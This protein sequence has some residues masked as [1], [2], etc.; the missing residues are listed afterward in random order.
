MNQ[1]VLKAIVIALPLIVSLLLG[2][3]VLPALALLNPAA[4]YC[5]SLG[6]NYTVES[7]QEGERGLCQLPN[8]EAVD[9]WQFLQGKVAPEYSYCHSIGCEIRTVS[10]TETCS[11]FLTEECAVCVLEDG[12]EI[13]VTELMG[14]SFEETVCGDGNCGFPENFAGC[15]QDCPSG[16]SDAY[17]DGVRDGIVDPDCLEGYDPDYAAEVEGFPFI[18]VVVAAV[19]VAAVVAVATLF[20]KRRGRPTAKGE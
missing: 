6:Y 3:F 1:N 9:A 18:P 17:C 13:E 10:D 11:R 5:H 8:G 7:T 16:G 14:L 15:P 20:M 2:I 12:T 19:A 4:V